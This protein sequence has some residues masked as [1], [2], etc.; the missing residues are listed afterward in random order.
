MILYKNTI[1]KLNKSGH[2]Y[3]SSTQKIQVKKEDVYR[4]GGVA[5]IALPIAGAALNMRS[6]RRAARQPQVVTTPY[7]SSSSPWAPQEPYLREA[8]SEAQNLYKNTPPPTFFPGQTYASASPETI[9]ARERTRN[10]SLGTLTERTIAQQLANQATQLRRPEAQQAQQQARQSLQNTLAGNY[11]F[12]GPGFNAALQAAQNRIIPQ[13]QSSFGARGRAGSGLAQAA[14]AREIG[15][16]FANQYGQ[17]RQ[18]QLKAASMLPGIEDIESRRL[19]ALSQ[20]TSQL[21]KLSDIDYRNIGALATVGQQ[22]EAQEQTGIDEAIRRYNF[23]NW[24]RTQRPW[25][26][27][28]RYHAVI[29]GAHGGVTSGQQQ[30]ISPV[31]GGSLPGGILSGALQGARLGNIF[32]L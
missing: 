4:A 11:L 1:I 9:A 8:F 12:G 24:Y 10:R 13:I 21:P 27:L 7:T 19:S 32:G 2:P 5:P 29:S 26:N 3:T 28:A 17:E 20:A 18:N 15:D 25:E 6:Q 23:G 14:A 30:K 22:K 31:H 16:V